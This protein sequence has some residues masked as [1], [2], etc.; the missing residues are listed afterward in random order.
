MKHWIKHPPQHPLR[1][2]LTM[3]DW[4]RIDQVMQ[5][6]VDPSYA[7]VEELDAAYD[8]LYDAV[9]T[10]QQTHMGILSLQ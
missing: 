9:A 2:K 10:E 6:S 3:E 8:V 7:T 5:G 1:K 4:E